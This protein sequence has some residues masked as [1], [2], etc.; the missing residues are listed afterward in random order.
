[1]LWV[2]PHPDR[3]GAGGEGSRLGLRRGGRSAGAGRGLCRGGLLAALLANRGAVLSVD[4]LFEVLWG[5]EPPEAA[6][7][8]LHAY[9]SR[10]RRLLPPSVSLETAALR[11]SAAPRPGASTWER[12]EVA[13]GEALRQ[14]PRKAARGGARGLEEAR[15]GRATVSAGV[16]WRSG[17]RREAARLDEL[18]LHVARELDA[19]AL[20]GLGA[21]GG[22]V[23]DARAVTADHPGRERA[24]RTL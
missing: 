22:G 9:L 19:E 1:M 10:L 15:F 12:F 13:L 5:D 16:R 11:L 2:L 14:A 7:S 6:T 24:W 18:H 4:R 23:S 3:V 20:L 8:S 17:G 21:R